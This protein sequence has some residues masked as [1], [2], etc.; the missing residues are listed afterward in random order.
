MTILSPADGPEM[1]ACM[2]LALKLDSPVYLRMGKADLGT[3]HTATPA[4]APGT[5][6]RLKKGRGPLSWIATGSMVHTAMKAAEHWPDSSVWSAP[7]IKP[8]DVATVAAICD[9]SQ[10]V[11]VLEEH[12]VYGGLGSAVVEISAEHAPT[13]VLRVGVQDR[14]SKYCGSYNYLMSEHGLSLED[15]VGQV[16]SY[17]ASLDEPSRRALPLAPPRLP[18]ASRGGIDAAIL[19][20]A[21]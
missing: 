15:V 8:L 18:A 13:R 21:P 9:K 14:F 3:V 10:A 17:L 11:I 5:L 16:T 19:T 6:L 12:S 7:C 1:T 20:V 2:D 4:I